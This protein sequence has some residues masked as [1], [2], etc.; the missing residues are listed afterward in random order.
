[1]ATSQPFIYFSSVARP[2]A[3]GWLFTGAFAWCWYMVVI[4]GKKERKWFVGMSLCLALSMYNHYFSGL[5]TILLWFLGLLLLSKSQRFKYILTAACA[6]LLFAAHIPMS[7]TQVGYGGIGGPDGYHAPPNNWF[8]WDWFRSIFHYHTLVALLATALLVAALANKTNRRASTVAWIFTIFFLITYTLSHVYSHV[9][10]PLLH[11]GTLFFASPMLIIACCTAI[12]FTGRPLLFAAPMLGVFM[13]YS[14]IYQRQHFET[15]R[16]Q[17][18][19][20][21]SQVMS[22]L[23]SYQSNA[24]AYVH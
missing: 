10:N 22:T 3:T 1:M 4:N 12:K 7:I 21:T 14:L 24:I 19:A 18:F 23:H 9:V 13:L 2:Y 20:G 16:S 5:A 6:F 11:H 17:P 15:F 8:L